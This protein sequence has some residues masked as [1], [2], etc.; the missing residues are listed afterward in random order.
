MIVL[1]A[2]TETLSISSVNDENVSFSHDMQTSGLN[3]QVYVASRSSA[4]ACRPLLVGSCCFGH[5]RG[6][7]GGGQWALGTDWGT[8]NRTLT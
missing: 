7:G 4:A 5:R 2:Y 3:A 1:V 8:N 6:G